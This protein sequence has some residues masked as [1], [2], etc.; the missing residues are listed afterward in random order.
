MDCFYAAIEMRD[1]ESLKGIP[2]AVGGTSKRSVLCTCNYEARSFGVKSAMPTSQAIKLCPQLKVV[3]G[4]MSKYKEVSSQIR[5]VF[6]QFTDLVEPLS[7]DEAYLDVTDCTE[8]SGSAT[9]IALEI[10]RLITER[11]KL[12]ASAGVAPNKFLA[13]IA[14]DWNKPNG[15]FVITPKEIPDFVKQLDVRKISGVGKVSA[16]KL[17]SFGVNKCGDLY[18]YSEE[19]LISKFGSLGKSLYYFSRG[20]D[21]RIVD[22]NRIRKSL[23]VEETY[24]DDL[25][26]LEECLTHMPTLLSE[27]KKRFQSFYNNNKNEKIT[28]ST[29][30]VKIKYYDFQSITIEKTRDD[31]VFDGLLDSNCNLDRL[32]SLMIRLLKSGFTKRNAPVRLLGIGVKFSE[33]NSNQV[34]LSLPLKDE[35]NEYI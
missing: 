17:N 24:L 35:D 23:S 1:D 20:I 8:F 18:K 31:S 10:K 7:L 25:E 22:N 15:L 34:Q 9:L 33:N 4:D 21:E 6:Y 28:I 3:L 16:E 5:K 30:C 2:I 32:S 26:T 27:L 12:T 11:T 14:S 13:K 29:A 19:L